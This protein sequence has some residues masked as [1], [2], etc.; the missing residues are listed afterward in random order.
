[1]ENNTLKNTLNIMTEQQ[2]NAQKLVEEIKDRID[3][4][5]SDVKETM[6]EINDL[7]KEMSEEEQKTDLEEV[8]EELN[9]KTI[10]EENNIKQMTLDNGEVIE[11]EYIETEYEKVPE[12][13]TVEELE[14]ELKKYDLQPEDYTG[15]S[16]EDMIE[17]ANAMRERE[18]LTKQMA[19]AQKEFNEKLLEFNN[20]ITK[21]SISGDHNQVIEI[22]TKKRDLYAK[23]S[24]NKSV[25]EMDKIIN[26]VKD[27]LTLEILF[28]KGLKKEETRIKILSS[29]RDNYETKNKVFAKKLSK[30]R[31]YKF[32]YLKNLHEYLEKNYDLNEFDSKLFLYTLYGFCH[33]EKIISRYSV[34][35]NEI[36]KNI[37]QPEKLTDDQKALFKA[38]IL[39]V[40]DFIRA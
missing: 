16:R 22:L 26:E 34:L 19:E 36:I 1:M 9:I 39:K 32:I 40:L 13:I 3:Y 25:I 29:Y 23:Y 2:E 6:E 38:S 17:I 15:I 27:S 7:K 12:N 18:V 35:I 20:Q 11:Y 28:S 5:E 24:K 4:L 33:N 10:D 21:E 8:E 37:I 14:E 31:K 30:N